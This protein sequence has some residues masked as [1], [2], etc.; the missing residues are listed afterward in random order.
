MA[1]PLCGERCNCS[2]ASGASASGEHV[3]VLIDPD[4]SD[5]SEAQ[6]E[7]SLE[8]ASEMASRYRTIQLE[9]PVPKQRGAG[10]PP[11]I[12]EEQWRS[13]VS[14]RVRRYR[15]RKGY[16]TSACLSLDFETAAEPPAHAVLDS[17]GAFMDIQF[18][19]DPKEHRPESREA[20]FSRRRAEAAEAPKVIEFPRP[21][22]E[23]LAEPV[24]DRPRILEAPAPVQLTLEDAPLAITLDPAPEPE[25]NYPALE[26]FEVP[27]QVAPLPLRAMA[28]G[29]DWL[30]VMFAAACFA[31]VVTRMVDAM[32]QG[33]SAFGLALL[34]V[35]IFW[36]LYQYVFLV[37]GTMTP[38][39]Q[40]AGL[41]LQRFDAERAGCDQ[42]RVRAL[43]LVLSFASVGLGFAWAVVDE[44][45]L[46]WHDRI[47]R[48][49]LST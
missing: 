26:V 8:N 43:S 45:T 3:A 5:N 46:C 29:M 7:A 14:S 31:L 4:I 21:A 44:D 42:R 17:P 1:C 27:I 30:L 38:G 40:F 22:A 33:K 36:S 2:Y 11:P 10:G 16:D 47:S 49:Y 12:S 19:A 37:Y 20:A 48:T 13:E 18:F 34:T 35:G 32:P 24:L 9:A 6:F 23:E 28:A 41:R 25:Q 39:M 15:H